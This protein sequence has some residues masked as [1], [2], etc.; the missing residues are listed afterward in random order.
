MP[1]GVNLSPLRGK[2]T[3]CPRIN[4]ARHPQDIC[5]RV[6]EL[7]GTQEAGRVADGWTGSGPESL[8]RKILQ[9]LAGWPETGVQLQSTRE[10]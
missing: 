5:L 10:S 2:G 7:R 8:C 9:G 1:Q 3:N 6:S 4:D